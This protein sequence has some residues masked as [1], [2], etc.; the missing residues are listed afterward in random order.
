LQAFNQEPVA[1]AIA[2]SPIPV[3]SAVGHEVDVTIADFVAD[4][5][6]PTPSAAAELVVTAKEEFCARVSRLAQRLTSAARA[7]VQRRRATVHTLSSRRGLAGWQARLAMRGRHAAELTHQLR[8]TA[9]AHVARRNRAYGA[10]RLRL[11]S[12]D[13]RRHLAAIRSRLTAATGRL[14]AAGGT[15]RHRA[16]ARLASIAGRLENLS[17]LAVL[18]RGYAVC[19]NADRSAIIRSAATVAAGD[20][21]HV[22]LQHGEIHCDVRGE[23]QDGSHN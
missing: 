18:G 20:R 17:P 6:A 19:W 16:R 3:V 5:R 2:A 9:S 8:R 12:R 23:E 15:A 4:L 22:R 21:V 1:R 11:E 7:D 14:E 13:L 10:L